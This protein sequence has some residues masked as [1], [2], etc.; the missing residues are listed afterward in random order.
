M[1]MAE[2]RTRA[3]SAGIKTARKTKQALIR[4]IQR[5]EGNRDCYDRGESQVCGQEGCAWRD[6]CK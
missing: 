4:E 5:T 2:I 3:R 6:N 1:K